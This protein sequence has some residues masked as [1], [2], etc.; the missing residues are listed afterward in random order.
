[1]Y[2]I[3]QFAQL[4]TNTDLIHCILERFGFWRIFLNFLHSFLPD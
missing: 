1:M 3:F 2:E 4:N